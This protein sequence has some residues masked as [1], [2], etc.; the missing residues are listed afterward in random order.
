MQIPGL[1]Y[2]TIRVLCTEYVIAWNILTTVYNAVLS[3]RHYF[4]NFRNHRVNFLCTLG[5]N[6]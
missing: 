2:V 3:K 4:K 5:Y 6:F 1:R